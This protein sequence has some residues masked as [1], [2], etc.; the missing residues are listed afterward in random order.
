M[1]PPRPP[2]TLRQVCSDHLDQQYHVAQLLTSLRHE[3]RRAPPRRLLIRAGRGHPLQILVR[4]GDE[5]FVPDTPTV[6]VTSRAPF[7]A[8]GSTPH[9][10]LHADTL[11]AAQGFPLRP[12]GPL[13]APETHDAVTAEL[14]CCPDRLGRV[15]ECTRQFA[16]ATDHLA[17][18]DVEYGPC[19]LQAAALSASE[20]AKRLNDARSWQCSAW[21]DLREALSAL[22][23]R[24]PY[25]PLQDW[26]APPVPSAH[27]IHP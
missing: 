1:T 14:D 8:P 5:V 7:P 16:D 15:A 12:A 10:R 3:C 26:P 4:I 21:Q 6:E 27:P 22:V 19:G 13:L 25:G 11:Q 20:R 24:V 9:V 23:V 2:L 18:A 17:M